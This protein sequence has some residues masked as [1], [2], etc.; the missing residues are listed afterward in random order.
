MAKLA[1]EAIVGYARLDVIDHK[2]DFRFGLWNS[3][4]VEKDEVNKLVQSFLTHGADRFSLSKAIPL[5]V[6]KKDLKEGTYTTS[7][8]PGLDA[9]K[10]L[11]I[12][13][14]ASSGK[15][16]R[17]LIAA[18]GRHRIHAVADWT[19]IL[20]KQHKEL[21]KARK[22][23]AKPV[24]DL[25]SEGDSTETEIEEVNGR[26]KQKRDIL[27]ETLALGGQWMVVLYDT[28]EQVKSVD[29]NWYSSKIQ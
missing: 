4:D 9:T 5:V 21:L 14:L 10:D 22:E 6:S 2:D 19:K 18:G 15:K 26:E 28:S 12:L 29:G 13:Q 20:T 8:T 3:R 1:Q 17:K 23:E 11:P 16:G 25:D 7:Y 27:Q 24:L